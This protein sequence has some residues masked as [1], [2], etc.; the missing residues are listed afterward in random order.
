MVPACVFGADV[1]LT[2]V[3]TRM[4]PNAFNYLFQIE[5]KCCMYKSDPRT[6]MNIFR[7]CISDYNLSTSEA[8]AVENLLLHV[9]PS[10]K[11]ALAK[12]AATYGMIKGPI[13][14]SGIAS[15][16][17]RTS[18]MVD[19]EVGFYSG[20]LGNDEATVSL[21]LERIKK[22][23]A[24]IVAGMRSTASDEKVTS[25]QRI[26]RMWILHLE[27]LRSRLPG[28]SYNAELASLEKSFLSGCFDDQLLDR[29]FLNIS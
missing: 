19:T 22:D 14:H 15:R 13:S 29:S 3:M 6:Q 28:L 1:T 27:D 21:I 12:I 4:K 17:L 26:C 23:F 11:L 5:K 9:H 8:D 20:K 7:D 10:A 25:L 16:A 24:S 18:Y 2:S